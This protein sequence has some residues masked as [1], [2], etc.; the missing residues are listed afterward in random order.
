MSKKLKKKK[1]MPSNH[2]FAGCGDS[3]EGIPCR[4]QQDQGRNK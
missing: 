4:E 2:Y 1:K 3:V